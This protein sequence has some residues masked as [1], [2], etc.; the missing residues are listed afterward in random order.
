MWSVI[1]PQAEPL[2]ATLASSSFDLGRYNFVWQFAADS[3][4]WH[5]VT[6]NADEFT[7]SCVQRILVFASRVYLPVVLRG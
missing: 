1:D 2:T 5:T 4:G 6:L 3:S 7:A